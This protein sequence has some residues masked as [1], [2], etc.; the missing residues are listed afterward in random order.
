MDEDRGPVARTDFKSDE[1]RQT[2][3]VG[4]TPTLFRQ[5][6]RSIGYSVDAPQ[7]RLNTGGPVPQLPP[8]T[9]EHAARLDFLEG[10][11]LHNYRRH[12]RGVLDAF[13]RDLGELRPRTKASAGEHIKKQALYQFAAAIQHHAQVMGWATAADSLRDH[14]D[15]LDRLLASPPANPIGRLMLDESL[16]M[17]GYYT[18]NDEAG[19]DDIHLMPG[20]YWRESLVGPIYE[21]G[22]ALYRTPWRVGYTASPPAAL[23]EFAKGA[24]PARYRRILDV[25]CSFGGSTMAFRAAY[26]NAEEIVGLDLSAP[27]LRWAHISAEERGLAIT[28]EQGDATKMKHDDSSFDLVTGF[29]LAHEVTAKVLDRI[30]SE[31]YRVLRPGGHIRFLDLPPFSELAPEVAFL[32]SFD[33]DGNG[34]KFWNEFLSSD[35]KATLQRAGFINV[36]DGPLEYDEPNYSGTAAL[37][38]TGEF[39]RENRWVTQA[40]KP[41]AQDG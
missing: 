17:P 36:T 25:G 8:V 9:Q 2:S 18:E 26:P 11:R 29:L 1:G 5:S 31:A 32:Q 40:D 13:E 28:Y 16:A 24:P 27:A 37:M 12:V 15:E 38:R 35:F 10:L 33:N 23:V 14:A 22:G 3:L 7:S 19:L 34:E 6:P 39:R 4:S 41:E 21:R 30:L 20:G